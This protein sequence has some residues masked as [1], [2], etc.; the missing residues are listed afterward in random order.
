MTEQEVRER[1]SQNIKRC[2]ALHGWSQVKLAEKL[3]VSANFIADIETG[4]SWI[5]SVTLTKLANIFETDVCN[6]FMPLVTYDDQSRE[7]VDQFAR[8]AVS[9]VRT[10]IERLRDE[11]LKQRGST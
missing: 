6:L 7:V 8:D 11:Y 9:T 4:K 1:L 2:R 3:E 10:S 5:S